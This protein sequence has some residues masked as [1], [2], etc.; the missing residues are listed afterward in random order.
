MIAFDQSKPRVALARHRVPRAHIECRDI[1][2][3]FPAVDSSP[4]VV[5]ASLC[6]HYFPWDETVSIV[7]RI[8]QLLRPG[9]ILVCRLNSTLDHNYGASGHPS[10]EPGYCLV[11]GER[12]R[13]FDEASIRRLFCD[14]WRY[15]SLEQYATH[16]Y[17]LPKALWEVVLE[18]ES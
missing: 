4:G 12:K 9:G 14:G 2:D 16:K 18:R 5:I 15:L 10:I 8:R 6:L 17:P 11:D 7:S 13:F 3:A 1:R